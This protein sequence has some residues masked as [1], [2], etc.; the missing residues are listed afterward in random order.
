M[1]VRLLYFEGCPHVD[2]ARRVLHEALSKLAEPPPIVEIDVTSQSAPPELRGWG[3]PTI[4][5][6]G[7]DVAGGAPSGACCR[8]YPDSPR[9]GAPSLTVIEAALRRAQRSI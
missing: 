9:R 3:S 1:Q 2:G 6:D 7:V 4:L 8:L 5:V